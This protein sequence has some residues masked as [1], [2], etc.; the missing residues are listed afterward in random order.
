MLGEKVACAAVSP[1]PVP[2]YTV[3]PYNCSVTPPPR[4]LHGSDF[5]NFSTGVCHVMKFTDV[6]FADSNPVIDMEHSAQ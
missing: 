2:I 4:Q 1:Q 6:K 3:G 5:G